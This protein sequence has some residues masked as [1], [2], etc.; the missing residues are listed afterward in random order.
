MLS[1]NG[2]IIQKKKLIVSMDRCDFFF[3]LFFLF[4]F[5]SNDREALF[6]YLCVCMG[7]NFSPFWSV[8]RNIDIC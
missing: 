3:L 6:I 4:L 8:F 1:L 2:E 5:R 7:L